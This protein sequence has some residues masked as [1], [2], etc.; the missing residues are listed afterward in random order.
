MSSNRFT[1]ILIAALSLAGCFNDKQDLLEF[2]EKVATQ[3]KP[4]IPPIRQIPEFTHI[5]YYASQ[6]QTSPF[7]F[8]NQ[9]RQTES[10][11]AETGKSTPRK[12]DCNNPKFDQAT[13]PLEAF[14]LE[15]LVMR[16]IL[17]SESLKKAIVET[18]DSTLNIVKKGDVIGTFHGKITDIDEQSI[19]VKEWIPD[20]LGCYK[21]RQ[22]QIL[23]TQSALNE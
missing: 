8:S 5:P 22:N 2:Q 12:P 21:S 9:S 10:E 4:G 19:T 14:A 16:G 18:N 3:I 1:F 11:T 17:Y 20:A 7:A 23:L 13:H 6:K 15:T